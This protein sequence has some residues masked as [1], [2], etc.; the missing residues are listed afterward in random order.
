MQISEVIERVK[1]YHRGIGPQQKRDKVL[2]GDPERECTGIV[3]TCWASAEV[4]REA[5]RLGANLIICHEALFWN[6]GDHTAWLQE[7]QNVA[8]LDKCALLDEGGIVVWRDHDHIHSGIPLADGSYVDGIFY[9]LAAKLGWAGCFTHGDAHGGLC[10]TIPALK[11]KELS[12]MLIRKLHLNG[13]RTA[14]DPEMIV[15]NVR[16]TPH[17]LGDANALIT[18]AQ[19]EQTDC[20]LTMEL[21]DFTLLEY[22]R[23]S[24]MLRHD[25]SLISMGHFNLEEPGMAYM[26]DYLPKA[27]GE[28]IPAYFVQS[29]DQYDYITAT[30]AWR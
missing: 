9:G 23:D 27:V 28:A 8:F 29:G 24:G 26:L 15:R 16:I 18:A 22:V 11:M 1:R 20:F 17:I 7:T 12:G 6:H 13:V 5:M 2:Y 14:G 19:Q 4:I 3:T 25:R 30:E 10:F 21:V